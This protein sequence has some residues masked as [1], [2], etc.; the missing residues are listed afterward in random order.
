MENPSG[1]QFVR[2]DL[3]IHSF[4]PGGSFDVKDSTMTPEA[5]VDLAIAKGLK[6]ISI[7]DHNEITNVKTAISYA[8]GKDILVVP[9]IEVSTTQGHLLMYFKEYSD[10]NKF[11]GKLNIAD[12]KETCSQSIVDCLTFAKQ[13]DGIG[14]LAHVEIDAGF[15]KTIGKFNQHMEAIILHPALWGLEISTKK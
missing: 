6:V 9:G 4:G 14:I 11:V 7:T 1:A 15:E 3:H 12:N 8:A 5:I 2:A 10:L 13:F